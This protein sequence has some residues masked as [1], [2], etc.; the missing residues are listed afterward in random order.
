MPEK[1]SSFIEFMNAWVGGAFT[2]IV[3]ALLGRI[4]WHGSEVS[5]GRRRFFGVELLWDIPLVVW[6]ALIG[7]GLSSYLQ[8]GQPTSAG[9]IGVLAYLGPR[10]VEAMVRKWFDR[11]NLG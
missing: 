7:E 10:G 4:V 11:H 9:L 2:A 1:Y 3:A 6:L 5:K 8:L